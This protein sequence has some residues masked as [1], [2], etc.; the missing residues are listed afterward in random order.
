MTRSELTAART[1]SARALSMDPFTLDVPAG[2]PVQRQSA[3]A[4]LSGV[5]DALS[6]LPA[7]ARALQK[8]S[9]ERIP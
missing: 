3:A 9:K 7:F 8:Q 4:Q 2:T 1:L 5:V 6:R